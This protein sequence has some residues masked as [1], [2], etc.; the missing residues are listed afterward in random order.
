MEQG[1]EKELLFC[2]TFAHEGEE[3]RETFIQVKNTIW[4]EQLL[5]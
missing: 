2:D 4:R 1:V 5:F 3:V